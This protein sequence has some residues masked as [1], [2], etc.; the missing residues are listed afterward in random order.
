MHAGS[1]LLAAVLAVGIAPT[2]LAQAPA[3]PPP[4][5]PAAQDE[6]FNIKAFAVTGNTILPQDEIARLVAPF[7]G[8][9]RVYGD[10]QKALEA[11]EGAYRLR[12]FSAV[13]VFVPEQTLD[14]GIVKL[15]VVEAKVAV[16]KIEG[17]AFFDDANIRAALPALQPGKTP[18]A[19]DIAANV[20][21]ANENPARQVDVVLGVGDKEDEVNASVTVSDSSPRKFI[22][23]LDNTGSNATGM[24]RLSLGYQH[25]NLF[26]ADHVLTAQY[27]TSV[28]KPDLVSIYSL[29][30]RVPL[31]RFDGSVD[32]F[33]AKSSVSSGTTA[34]VAG[35]LTFTGKGNIFGL[36][37]NQYLARRGE[38]THQI[39][40]GFD[41][42]AFEN[43]CALGTFG[44]AGCGPAALPITSHPFSVTYSG[45]WAG[46]GRQTGFSVSAAANW[47]WGQNGVMENFQAVR[48]A[49][50]GA[51][52]GGASSSFSVLKA[53]VSHAEVLPADLQLRAGLSG[54]W[55]PQA[56]IP[57]E[58][59]GLAGATSV[60]GFQEREF[61]R[62]R[63]IY[64]NFEL[65]GPDWGDKF[66]AGSN[67]RML[68]FYDVARG[69]NFKLPGDADQRLAIAS[70]GLGLRFNLGK[71]LS[72][73]ADYARV[74][75]VRVMNATS[76]QVKGD[77]RGHFSLALTF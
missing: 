25:A 73:K 3:P 61:A 52:Q 76:S 22:S 49:A 59:F 69:Y 45:G 19:R 58:Q 64:G 43:A 4:A 46:L 70:V 56:L 72:I 10:I 62:D 57:Q 36:R 51:A 77:A 1:T 74:T 6:T 5:Q 34:T 13:Q 71:N 20:R 48:P 54:Q 40:Y 7:T 26:N 68:V 35:P 23:S 50:A 39:T 18:N 29:S 41:Y 17:H 28:E 9:K 47:A 60:R 32:A 33:Y 38:F 14:T 24:H 27:T 30:Y 63:G 65:Y 66:V 12:G 11:L 53:S 55:T 21:V 16:I 44:A 8:D 37:F 15:G 42:K 75:D 31:Y 67:L 2:A